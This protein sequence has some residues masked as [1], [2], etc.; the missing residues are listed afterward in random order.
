MKLERRYAVV[1]LG[2]V[3]GTSFPPVLAQIERV[4]NECRAER[5]AG[6]LE[7]LVIERDWPEYELAFAALSA[8]VDGAE[9]NEM[10]APFGWINASAAETIAGGDRVSTRITPERANDDDLALFRSGIVE[11][12]VRR[13]WMTEVALAAHS[14][15]DAAV[16][17]PTSNAS[18][19]YPIMVLGV[20]DDP[21]MRCNGDDPYVD[22]VAYWPATKQWT[23][24]HQTPADE[25]AT[26][27]PVR[28]S[29]WKP[30][31]AR[32]VARGG[33]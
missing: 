11:A 5:G 24:T 10:P 31:P 32:P 20:V 6:P 28:V 23:C 27:C 25:A 33:T 1:K 29:H 21:E 30:R 9:Q 2:D 8:R 19:H 26:D 7:A 22:V 13:L 4:A 12:L 3:S 17:V 18:P 15:I 16:R 14:W